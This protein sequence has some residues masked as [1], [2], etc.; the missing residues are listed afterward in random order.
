MMSSLVISILLDT[1]HRV[2]GDVVTVIFPRTI[3]PDQGLG[4]SDAKET[5][6]WIR[7]DG[8]G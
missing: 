1:G 2:D 5:R 7:L 6:F 3:K 8:Y 4:R